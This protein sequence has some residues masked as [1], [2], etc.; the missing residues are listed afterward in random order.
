VQLG[1]F[2]IVKHFHYFILIG[3]ASLSVT[4]V[5]FRPTSYILSRFV[6]THDNNAVQVPQSLG[7]Y[8]ITFTISD[9]S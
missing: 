7:V 2:K 6:L 9:S 3:L 1:F 5:L 8:L 4:D